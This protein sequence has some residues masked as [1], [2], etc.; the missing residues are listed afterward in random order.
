MT[1]SLIDRE[2]PK[3]ILI[4]HDDSSTQGAA[5][6]AL[7]DL[8][9]SL[10]NT[11]TDESNITTLSSEENSD[12]A[13]AD[14]IL[15]KIE[16]CAQS[17]QTIAVFYIGH[18][19]LRSL[20][21]SESSEEELYL[22]VQ[23]TDE[24]HLATRG[25][26][27]SKLWDMLRATSNLKNVFMFLNIIEISNET[28]GTTAVVETFIGKL[29]TSKSKT[30]RSLL[31]FSSDSQRKEEVYCFADRFTR[32]LN[33]GIENGSPRI[34]LGEIYN[35]LWEQQLKHKKYKFISHYNEAGLEL[36][37]IPFINNNAKPQDNYD[38]LISY[39]Q[40]LDINTRR[41]GE[42]S[43]FYRDL[44]ELFASQNIRIQMN[45]QVINEGVNEFKWI[46]EQI[47]KKTSILIIIINKVSL[48]RCE[49]CRF[50]LQEFIST[51]RGMNNLY[52]ITTDIDSTRNPQ[53]VPEEHSYEL[54][55]PCKLKGEPIT[56]YPFHIEDGKLSLLDPLNREDSQK[57]RYQSLLKLLADDLLSKLRDG[58]KLK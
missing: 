1:N 51:K 58:E 6:Q 27:C 47:V 34:T 7:L 33:E 26:P 9:T 39:P 37:Q 49:W 36:E 10:T 12:Y 4:C 23:D 43:E 32:A 44:R 48:D 38:I 16:E 52:V 55:L 25:I 54:K 42:V 2:Y 19:S 20:K 22:F 5:K 11:F 3:A 8:K 31:F 46:G 24:K 14:D 56:H 45:Y 15:L 18:G 17:A 41:R 30:P 40:S 57:D 29:D 28:T 53:S 21:K 35:F 13:R 50:I